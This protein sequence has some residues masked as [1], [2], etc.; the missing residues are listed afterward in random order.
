MLLDGDEFVSDIAQDIRY[1]E[2]VLNLEYIPFYLFNNKTVIQG[3]VSEGDYLKTLTSSFDE[4][5]KNGVSANPDNFIS[6]Q[7][8]SIDGKCS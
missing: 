3:S 6:G 8:C 5:Q 1:S 4:W 2:D 7:A